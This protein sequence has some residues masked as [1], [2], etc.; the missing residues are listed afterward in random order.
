MLRWLVLVAMAAAIRIRLFG[1]E[2]Y[3]MYLDENA[4]YHHWRAA[5]TMS[6]RGTLEGW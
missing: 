4:P 3:G 6:K 5:Q 2:K 1:Y